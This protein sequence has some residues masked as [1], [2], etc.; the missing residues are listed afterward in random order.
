MERI[1]SLHNELIVAVKGNGV[2][3]LLESPTETVAHS[4]EE[5]LFPKGQENISGGPFAALLDSTG[6]F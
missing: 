3:P 6:S 5:P 2:F 1:S 4:D